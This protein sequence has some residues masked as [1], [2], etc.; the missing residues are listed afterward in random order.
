MSTIW[1]LLWSFQAP[2]AAPGPTS[3]VAEP[4]ALV[5]A[6]KPLALDHKCGE[7]VIQAL[8][9]GC[10]RDEPCPIY[11]ELASLEVAGNS[12]FVTGN[13]H[14]ELVTLDSVL[15]AS[16]D[17]GKTWREAYPR[18]R[19]GVVDQVQFID[20]QNG[21]VAGQLMQT[22]PRDPFFLITG[23]GGKTWRRRPLFDDNRIA[24]IDWFHFTSKSQGSLILDRR[25]AGDPLAKY[26]AYETSTGG[27][28]W[29]VRE[30]SSKP[31]KPKATVPAD[32]D[33]RIRADGPS[34][35]FR[36]ERRAGAGW[37]TVA[38]FQVRLA[39]CLPPEPP[40]A[41]EPPAEPAPEPVAAPKPA[42]TGPRAP[43]SLKKKQS[44]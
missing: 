20:F 40:P 27:S 38:S 15:L 7:E 32:S 30:V 25:K 44:P 4:A 8:G 11:L 29:T 31:M 35:A 18:I 5:W 43:P 21:W 6:G 17:G 19:Q 41:V 23:D 42:V 24:T 12:L 26:E 1:L 16:D 2:A 39:D 28:S 22:I 13:I 34:K 14:S 33:W 3:P 36:I 37:Q 9:L 10:T